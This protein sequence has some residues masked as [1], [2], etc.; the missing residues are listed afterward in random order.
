V[1]GRLEVS[2]LLEREGA[3]LDRRALAELGLQRA[4]IDHVFRVLP[5]VSFPGV[6]RVYVRAEDFRRYVD[7]HTYV[8]DERVRPT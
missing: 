5:V 8:D 7:E 4:S 1:T 3:L 6:R 2:E